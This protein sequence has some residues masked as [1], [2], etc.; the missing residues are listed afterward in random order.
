MTWSNIAQ[1][2]EHVFK[3]SSTGII[4]ESGFFKGKQGEDKLSQQKEQY[5]QM[6][7]GRGPEQI[8][9]KEA[10]GA[11]AQKLRAGG[12]EQGEKDA[13]WSREVD[14]PDQAGKGHMKDFT[15][16]IQ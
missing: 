11:E 4:L 3:E 9:W 16:I 8:N 14:R 2:K 13:W 6:P 7:R 15:V 5:L 10:D 1:E 12:V